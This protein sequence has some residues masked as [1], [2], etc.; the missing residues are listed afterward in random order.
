[1]SN[2]RTINGGPLTGLIAATFTPLND[3]RTLNTARVPDIVEHL[4]D[5]GVSGLYVLG[6]TGEGLSLTVEER[7]EVAESFVQVSADRIPVIIQVGSES[8][9]QARNLAA[10]AQE[11]GAD[12][13]SAVSPVYF[14]P[15]S[16][17]TLVDS[18]AEIASGAPKLPFYYYHIPGVT[19][20]AYSMLDFLRLGSTTIPNLAGIKF[21]S[22]DIDEFAACVEFAG[23]DFQLLWGVDE[24]LFDGLNAGAQAAVGSTYNF[25][26]PIYQRLL[27]AFCNGN[28]DEARSQQQLAQSIV[29]AFVPFGLRSAQKAMMAMAG[30]DCGPCRLPLKTLNAKQT[31]ALREKLVSVGFFDSLAKPGS[32]FTA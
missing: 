27:S 5:Q 15:D 7:C 32:K 28:H 9:A 4:L 10:H 21:T 6:S 3:D 20:V 19:G 11:I 26:A 24:K 12:A 8:L 1:M 31:E 2:P 25:V 18:M 13:I 16:I 17:D 14:K 29:D 30:P 23:K 22:T